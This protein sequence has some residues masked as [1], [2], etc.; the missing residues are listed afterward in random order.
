MPVVFLVINNLYGMGTSVERASAEPDLFRRAGSYR[1]RGERVDGDDLEAVLEISR[2]LLE[3]ARAG[4]AG[5]P[6]SRRSPT[7]IAYSVADAGLAYRSR[8]EIGGTA[9]ATRWSGRGSAAGLARGLRGRRS[10]PPIPEAAAA[11]VR[12]TGI[13]RVQPAPAVDRLAAGM[14]APSSDIQFERMQPGSPHGERELVYAGLG[15]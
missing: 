6:C 11:V 14:Y 7:A 15:R 13:R 5:R 1:M 9:R 12:A 8:E 10:P 4:R 3:E 2:E